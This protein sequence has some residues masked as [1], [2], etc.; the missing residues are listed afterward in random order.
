MTTLKNGIGNYRIKKTGDAIEY[1]Y[2]GNRIAEINNTKKEFKL[3]SCGWGG[4]RSTTRALNELQR[5]YEDAGFKL[6]SRDWKIPFFIG[7]GAV[8]KNPPRKIFLFFKL[9]Y[10][11]KETNKMKIE[12]VIETIQKHKKGR[13]FV[14]RYLSDSIIPNKENKG[15]KIQKEVVSVVRLVPYGK[16]IESGENGA[17]LRDNEISIVKDYIK[18]NVDTNNYLVMFAVTK[19]HKH[20]SR[21]LNYFING[22]VSSFEEVAAIARPS[23]LV[24]SKPDK[25]FTIKAQN[26]IS[27]G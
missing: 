22:I 4:Y 6:V 16:L 2:H 25:V 12:K 26:I 7:M 8:L 10:R 14:I 3:H 17:K 5:L 24:S 18:L 20:K 9:I 11:H 13:Y 23:S 27:I 21:I 15:A 19:N 1:F